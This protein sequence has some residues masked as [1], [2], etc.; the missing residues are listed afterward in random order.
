[1]SKRKNTTK[2]KGVKTRSE[3]DQTHLS[4]WDA[5]FS[6][7]GGKLN[8][9]RKKKKAGMEKHLSRRGGEKGPRTIVME[10]TLN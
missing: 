5:P 3:A 2:K 10:D 4:S 7:K 8:V 1:M 6:E 9:V